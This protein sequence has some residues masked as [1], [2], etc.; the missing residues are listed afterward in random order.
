[1]GDFGVAKQLHL[2]KATSTVTKGHADFI[3]P[4]YQGITE[5]KELT[6][7]VSSMISGPLNG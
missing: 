7:E 1:L 5:Q 6:P 4:E 3:P 2:E